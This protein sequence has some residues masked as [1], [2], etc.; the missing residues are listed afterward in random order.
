MLLLG[1]IC[2]CTARVA[3]PDVKPWAGLQ[4]LNSELFRELR[5]R[6]GEIPPRGIVDVKS[7][8]LAVLDVDADGQQEILLTSGPSGIFFLQ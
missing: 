5:Q 4:P 1:S 7:T 8:G 2:G 6:S 3:D